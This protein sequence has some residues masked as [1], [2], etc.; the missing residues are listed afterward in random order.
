MLKFDADFIF[1][2]FIYRNGKK[3]QIL[4]ETMQE[5]ALELMQEIASEFMY[6]EDDNN[7]NIIFQRLMKIV[8]LTECLICV[9]NPELNGIIP[10]LTFKGDKLLLIDEDMEVA[11]PWG[12]DLLEVDADKNNFPFDNDKTVEAAKKRIEDKDTEIN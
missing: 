8:G 9:F 10:K 3:V 2:H 4:S 5:H 11:F 12:E 1:D 6:L 7:F